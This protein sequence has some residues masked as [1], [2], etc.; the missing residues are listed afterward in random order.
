[1]DQLQE[2]RLNSNIDCLN[3]LTDFLL[4]NPHMKLQQVLY[5]LD[6]DADVYLFN[7]EP[8]QTHERWKQQL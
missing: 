3:I 6:K 8:W 5:N 1:M 4:R 2:K 7:E